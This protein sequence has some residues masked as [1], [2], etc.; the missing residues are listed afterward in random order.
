MTELASQN[1]AYQNIVSSG[2][3]ISSGAASLSDKLA[4]VAAQFQDGGAFKTGV[5]KLASGT[6]QLYLNTDSLD[7]LSDGIGSLLSALEQLENGSEK[8]LTGSENLQDGL[9]S[10]KDGIGQLQDASEQLT[11]ADSQISEG[12]GDLQSGI[13]IAAQ[14]SLIK[15]AMEDIE[16]Y[17]DDSISTAFG[18]TFLLC[19]D[20]SC[21]SVCMWTVYR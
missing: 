21:G 19:R 13:G 10:V 15:T 14:S 16:Q 12:A 6:A 8:L 18:D 11:E 20:H 9:S 17:K 2:L 5:Q 7:T 1:A 3:A 4:Q